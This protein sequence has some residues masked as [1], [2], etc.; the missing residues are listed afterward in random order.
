VGKKKTN[1][2]PSVYLPPPQNY[3]YS[4]NMAY[5]IFYT[6]LFLLLVK[7]VGTMRD[8]SL[9]ARDVAS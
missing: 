7:K 9:T 6:N 4:F 3:L 1:L 8:V 2:N 5:V